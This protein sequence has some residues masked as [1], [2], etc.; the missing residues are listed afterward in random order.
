MF[1]PDPSAPATPPRI[2]GIADYRRIPAFNVAENARIL[3][4]YEFIERRLLRSMAG[5]LPGVARWEAKFLLGR[6][7][8]E[9]SEHTQTL[10]TRILELRTSE[11]ILDRAP[12]PNLALV[13][14][15]LVLADDW[16]EFLTGVAALKRALLAAYQRHLTQTQPLVDQPTV[17]VLRILIAEETEHIALL[18]EQIAADG[19]SNEAERT[20]LDAWAQRIALLLDA[21][22]GV[23]GIDPVSYA[24]RSEDLR[25][26]KKTFRCDYTYALDARFTPQVPRFIAGQAPFGDDAAGVYRSIAMGRFP[27]MQAA[28]GIALSIYENDGQPWEYYYL[29]ARHLWDE[30]RHCAMGQAMLED[31]GVD[32]TRL[33]H[34]VGNYHF[35][36]SLSPLERAIRL[37][38]IIEL[39]MMENG[40]KRR[41]VELARKHG[42][43]LA[44]TFQDYDWADE[45]N[46][47]D[48]ARRNIET[49]M[50]GDTSA[51]DGMIADINRRYAEFRAPWEAKGDKF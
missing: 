46:H 4:R 10:R 9:D 28:K 5:W 22:G 43:A 23:Q 18:D 15:E 39:A 26:G 16:R 21:A 45:V 36:A 2:A 31:Q 13:L 14:D 50:H 38:V 25:T 24:V 35:Y 42:L 47:V 29:S 30:V 19:G 34:F 44:E 41:E 27:E 48:Y 40:A 51:L 33:P 6:L 17:R 12:S 20:R 37:G 3:L 49:M 11:R 7:V 8:W 1:H 32:W